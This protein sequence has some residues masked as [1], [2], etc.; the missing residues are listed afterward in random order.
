MVPRVKHND[1]SWCAGEMGVETLR[2][3]DDAQSSTRPDQVSGPLSCPC[4]CRTRGIF[5]QLRAFSGGFSMTAL[6]ALCILPQEASVKC[7]S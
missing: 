3:T 1:E 2:F 6:R 4:S 7:V 5:S